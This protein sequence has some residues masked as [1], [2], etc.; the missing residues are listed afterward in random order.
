MLTSCTAPGA[1]VSPLAVHDRR[2]VR[3]GT[4]VGVARHAQETQGIARGETGPYGLSGVVLETRDGALLNKEL[5]NRLPALNFTRPNRSPC[6]VREGERRGRGGKGTE[7]VSTLH[8]PV[9]CDVM[10]EP[11]LYSPR[12]LNT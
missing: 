5:A 7:E 2:L 8:G 6:L 12:W 10:P 1:P 3:A 4:V 9:L 11:P